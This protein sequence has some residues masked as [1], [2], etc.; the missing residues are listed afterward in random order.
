MNVTI[1]GPWEDF[2]ETAVK[3]GRFGSP[4]DVVLEGLRLVEQREAQLQSL[5]E[6]LAASIEAGGSFTDEEVTAHLFG[7]ANDFSRQEG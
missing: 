5:R 2:V 3:T 4:D 7:R 1:P 6:T